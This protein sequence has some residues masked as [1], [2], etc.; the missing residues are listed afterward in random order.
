M[1]RKVSLLVVALLSLL[2]VQAAFAQE[3][4]EEPAV[5]ALPFIIESVT[6]SNIDSN[7][8]LDV[9]ATWPTGCEGLPVV[10]TQTVDQDRITVELTQEVGPLQACPMV[11]RFFEGQI[12]IA[13][14]F[15][16]GLYTIDLNGTT[17]EVQVGDPSDATPFPEVAVPA[18]GPAVPIQVEEVFSIATMSIPAQ[19]RTTVTGTLPTGCTG[20]PIEI[21]QRIEGD[22]VA[23][24]INQ[25]TAELAACPAM[26]VPYQEL[27]PLWGAYDPIPSVTANGVPEFGADGG[28][29]QA[30]GEERLPIVVENVMPLTTRSIPAQVVLIVSGTL[31]T[32]C[33]DL[34]VEVTQTRDG[35][36][37][38]VEIV[39]IVPENQMCTMAIVP[40]EEH[41]RLDGEFWGDTFNIT[42]NGFQVEPLPLG[43]E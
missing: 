11:L 36:N 9:V 26:I 12:L 19:V 8:Q 3:A 10:L 29:A 30:G 25:I 4:T 42:V 38:N 16:P 34:P 40:Y 18:T 33:D 7:I 1:F 39:Q 20:F 5:N 17:T 41:I 21:S 24:T 23:I 14:T 22:T 27:I 6:A 31:P 28:E 35:A 2:V 13:G 37:V 32:G 43:V 15:A